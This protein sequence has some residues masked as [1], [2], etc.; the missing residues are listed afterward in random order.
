MRAVSLSLS[1]AFLAACGGG[2]GNDPTP[3]AA[4]T[5][6]TWSP[7]IQKTWSLPA[8]GEKTSDLQIEPVDR[9]VVIGG[10][11]PLSPV[12]TH[13]TLLFKGAE[14]T[15]MVYA[16]GV[17]TGELMFPA[18]TGM[19]ITAGTLLGLQ[20]H[21]YNT[22]DAPLTGTSGIEILEVDPATV[23]DE[24]DMFLPGPQDLAIAPGEHT[25]SGTCTVTQPYKVFALF[26]HM[27]QLGSH[28]KTVVN[29]GGTEHVL[30]DA[31]YDFEHQT[32][33][34]F[35]PLQLNPGDTITTECTWMNT[36]NETVTYG[37]SSTTEM[38]YS[39]LYRYPRGN[40]EFCEN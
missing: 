38:C 18:G 10:M 28:M 5:F 11:R 25:Q 14:G 13:H 2:G 40:D 35:E 9:D 8:G 3:D 22:T 39:I 15:N 16:S 36:T 4:D 21:I 32:V 30:N 23:T 19:R 33:K 26:P 24:V 7:L 17:G 37:E 20:L 29:A 6:G 1:F 31:T 12:G 34:S 27:H